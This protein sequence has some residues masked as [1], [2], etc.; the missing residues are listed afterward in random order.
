MRKIS[1]ILLCVIVLLF[2]ADVM[3]G[4]LMIFDSGAE[5]DGA[6]DTET[7]LLVHGDIAAGTTAFVDSSANGLA[8]TTVGN[9]A[10]T[11]VFRKIGPEAVQFTS[12]AD[13]LTLAD[14]AYFTFGSGAFTIDFWVRM[15]G[16]IYANIFDHGSGGD[17]NYNNCFIRDN[18]VQFNA[19]NAVTGRSITLRSSDTVAKAFVLNEWFHI[20]IIRGWGGNADMMVL[21]INGKSTDSYDVSGWTDPGDPTTVFEIG[22]PSSNQYQ[23]DEFRVTKGKALWTTDFTPPRKEVCN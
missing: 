7:V 21:T 9:A 16:T 4:P 22:N 11:K 14:S 17:G 6:I 5:C 18:Y 19:N 3:A 13:S 10:Q 20:A 2:A 12:G 8:I 1:Q 23:I 15:T